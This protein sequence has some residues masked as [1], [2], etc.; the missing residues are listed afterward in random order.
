MSTTTQQITPTPE[1]AET[2]KRS[3]EDEENGTNDVDQTQQEQQQSDRGDIAPNHTIY[4]RNINERVK[5]PELKKQLYNKFSEFGPV[6]DI[7][8]KRNIKMRGQA[9]VVFKDIE[10]STMALKKMDGAEFFDSPI[11]SS[12]TTILMHW[13]SKHVF[14]F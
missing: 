1:T 6:L 3:R 13:K 2:K 7:I 10:S 8:A 5:I 12:R 11:V 14:A 9:F 4:I